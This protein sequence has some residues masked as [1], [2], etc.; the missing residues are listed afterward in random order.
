MDNFTF[1]NGEQMIKN[2]EVYI[3]KQGEWIKAL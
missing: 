1:K 3:S 2:W